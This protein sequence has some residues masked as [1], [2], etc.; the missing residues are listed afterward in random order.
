MNDLACPFIF[1][2][3]SEYIR[4][5]SHDSTTRISET[6]TIACSSASVN[7]VVPSSTPVVDRALDLAK[8]IVDN[9]SPDAIQAHKRGIMLAMQYEGIEPATIAHA[10]SAE[11]K[12]VYKGENIKVRFLLLIRG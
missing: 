10:W 1:L 3:S 5:I 9:C 12:K 6:L 8:E 11:S 4:L 7:I 2:S